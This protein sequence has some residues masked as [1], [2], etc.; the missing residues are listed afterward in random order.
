MQMQGKSQDSAVSI[1]R[2]N[3]QGYMD[4]GGYI[5]NQKFSSMMD[6]NKVT[7]VSLCGQW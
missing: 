5:S 1:V 3:F 4:H 2:T 7:S 6:T